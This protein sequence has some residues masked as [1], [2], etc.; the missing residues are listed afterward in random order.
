MEMKSN[1]KTDVRVMSYVPRAGIALFA[2]SPLVK[3][4]DACM[5]V[6]MLAIVMMLA[7]A[8]YAACRFWRDAQYFSKYTSTDH[9]MFPID[10]V[11]TLVGLAI[12][13][14]THDIVEFWGLYTLFVLS[15]R[16]WSK[17]NK[18]GD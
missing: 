17:K 9:G 2:V 8:A 4:D 12:A 18:S 6:M 16:L 3:D 10:L 15:E 1:D 11:T 5:A 7:A 14:Y 13:L